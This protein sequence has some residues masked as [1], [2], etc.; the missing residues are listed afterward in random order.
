MVRKSRWR[1]PERKIQATPRFRNHLPLHLKVRKPTSPPP[2]QEAGPSR[3]IP[4]K[5][6]DLSTFKFPE[7]PFKRVR[8]ELTE[9]QNQYFR[10]K[11]ITRGVNRALGNCGPGNI[12]RKLAKRTDQKHVETLETEKAQLAA[13]VAAM[14]R[15]RPKEQADP[16]VPGGTSCKSESDPGISGPSG[17]GRQQ[18]APLQPIDGVSG[19]IFRPTNAPDPG[20]VLPLDEGSAQGDLKAYASEWYPHMDALCGSTRISYRHTI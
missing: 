8:D 9:L 4:W 13:Q 14:P 15:A 7:A 1:K 2:R 18:G 20:K 17:R 3:E 11:H 12:L 5:D 19:S 10:M 16:E 6:I